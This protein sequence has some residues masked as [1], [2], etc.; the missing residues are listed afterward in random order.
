MIHE[1]HNDTYLIVLNSL[2]LKLIKAV[3]DKN[4][5]IFHPDPSTDLE[6]LNNWINYYKEKILEHEKNNSQTTII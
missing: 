3:D 1:Q 2:Q 6:A 5:H 4:Q